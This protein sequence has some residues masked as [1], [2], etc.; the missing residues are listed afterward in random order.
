AHARPSRRPESAA[1]I[2]AAPRRRWK[3]RCGTRWR[4]RT[5]CPDR[6]P[7]QRT[8]RCFPGEVLI[9]GEAIRLEGGG[10]VGEATPFLPSPGGGGSACM[11][12]ANARR[13]GVTVSQLG[14][15]S[16]GETVTPPR[17]SFHERRPSPSRV[18]LS[19]MAERGEK[20]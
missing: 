2:P 16:S 18:G 5:W 11:S 4:A 12:V 14:H 20:E 19:H 9:A 6:W 7:A 3:C 15:C 17:R 13:G 10:Q 1:G 8:W